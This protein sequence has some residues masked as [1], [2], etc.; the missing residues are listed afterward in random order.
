MPFPRVDHID[1][2]GVI[3]VEQWNRAV[4]I[5]NSVA[6]ITGDGVEHTPTGVSIDVQ[7]ANT[8]GNPNAGNVVGIVDTPPTIG[9]VDGSDED[10]EADS[11]DR[12][13]QVDGQLGVIERVVTRVVYNDAGDQVLY[14]F[15][16]E[17]TYDHLG[18]LV[19]IGTSTRYEVDATE[20]C[21][22][23]DRLYKLH[24]QWG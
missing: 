8:F 12:L 18:G 3:P 19:T 21:I 20:E 1:E 11:W 6:D 14:M 2:E 4:D 15:I 9:S 22:D 7:Q 5:L 13:N 23:E 17:N 10:A 16:R 24:N